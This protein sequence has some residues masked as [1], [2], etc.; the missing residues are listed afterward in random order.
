MK[1]IVSC[2]PTAKVILNTYELQLQ[3]THW[4]DIPDEGLGSVLFIFTNA[5]VW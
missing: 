4:C 1:I 5:V 3:T 2:S